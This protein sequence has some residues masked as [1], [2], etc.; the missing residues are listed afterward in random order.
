MK[1]GTH[2]LRIYV[3]YIN[4]LF[5][6]ICSGGLL[7]FFVRWQTQYAVALLWS[8]VNRQD[9]YLYFVHMHFILS[10]GIVIRFFL[11]HGTAFLPR[12]TRSIAR[13]MLRQ[14]GWLAGWVSD[15]RRY[16]IKTAKAI[17]KLFRPS[18]FF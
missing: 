14:R 11:L 5:V 1:V 4:S 7:L 16:C 2:S 10:A 8:T 18:S 12:A 13:Y 6:G 15:T 17:L 3:C 9:F